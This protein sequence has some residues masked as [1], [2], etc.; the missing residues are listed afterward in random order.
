MQ[1][2]LDYKKESKMPHLP[3]SLGDMKRNKTGG[4]RSMKPRYEDKTPPCNQACPAGIDVVRFLM[5][6][7][8]GKIRDAWRTSPSVGRS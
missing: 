6:V 5:L 3:I 1:K 4:W 2:V 8:E 7:N